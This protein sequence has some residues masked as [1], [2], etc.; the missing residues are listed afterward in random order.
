M[1]VLEANIAGQTGAPPSTADELMGPAALDVQVTPSPIT[2]ARGLAVSVH[3]DAS[4][5]RLRQSP[6]DPMGP[7]SKGSPCVRGL[8]SAQ[9]LLD[10]PCVCDVRCPGFYRVFACVAGAT[11]CCIFRAFER[12]GGGQAVGRNPILRAGSC[13]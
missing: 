8:R 2:L 6:L 9:L 7:A 3:G 5:S 10:I 1:R 11:P 13:V 12:R 4:G